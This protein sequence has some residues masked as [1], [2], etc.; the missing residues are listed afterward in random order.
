MSTSTGMTSATKLH[1]SD[2]AKIFYYKIR[3]GLEESKILSLSLQQLENMDEEKTIKSPI[4]PPPIISSEKP[5]YHVSLRC[6]PRRPTDRPSFYVCDKDDIEIIEKY[7]IKLGYKKESFMT[8]AY[9]PL[10]PLKLFQ[11]DI[12]YNYNDLE[13]YIKTIDEKYE[14]SYNFSGRGN[15]IYIASCLNDKASQHNVDGW[16]EILAAPVA[17]LMSEI[18]LFGSA[19]KKL[20]RIEI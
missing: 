16:T 14:S 7:Y 4:L 13:R 20:K 8:F 15:N 18:M 6:E 11:L 19:I 2:T 10:E 1:E 12:E 3:L 5:I 17:L 9:I